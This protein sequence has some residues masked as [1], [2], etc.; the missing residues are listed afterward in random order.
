M[1]VKEEGVDERWS[2]TVTM[3]VIE[4]KELKIW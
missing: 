3:A 4:E 2:A 1:K